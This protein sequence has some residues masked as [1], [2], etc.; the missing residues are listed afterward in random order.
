M[1]SLGERFRVTSFGESHGRCIGIVVDGCP[2]G[3]PLSQRDIQ[4]EV[5]RRR[6]GLSP[7]TSQRREPDR[8]EILSGLFKGYTTGA[9]IAM[10][11]W[12]R[13]VDSRDYEEIRWKPRPGHADYAAHIKY[14]GFQDHRGGGRFSGRVTA[15]FVMAG[16]VAKRLLEEALNVEVLAHIVEIGGVKA[17]IREVEE[18]RKYAMENPLRCGDPEAARK[19]ERALHD[20][21]SQGDSVGG[22]VECLVLGLPPGVGEPVFDT[23]EGDIAKALYAIPGVKAV[24]FGLGV[25]FARARGSQVNDPY[26]IR[27][28]RVELAS[29]NAGGAFGGISVGAKISIRVTFKPTPSIAREQRTVDLRIMKPATMKMR[30]RH[31]PCIA[32]R[33][34]SAVEAMVAIVL[35]DH[36]LRAG[37]IPLVLEG[38]AHGL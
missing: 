30:G 10:L 32:L 12:N 3:L 11:I 27:D 2:A 16:A 38:R 18:L 24:E 33:G 26:I 7:L 36:S 34:A 25:N 19:M 21:V 35:A 37:L 23:L 31:D 4:R 14:G 28:G 20:A 1:N 22:A 29:D 8:V 5:D 15:G 13:D 6:A 9:P 17:E